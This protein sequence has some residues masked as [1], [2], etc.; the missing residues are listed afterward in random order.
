M[1]LSTHK[2]NDFQ[3]DYSNVREKK[4]TSFQ[5]FKHKDLKAKTQLVV[6]LLN[7]VMQT[8]SSMLADI[9]IPCKERDYSRT[10]CKTLWKVIQENLLY[11]HH[12]IKIY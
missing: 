12:L 5:V 6:S 2:I 9:V 8:C 4:L 1:V 7:T 10:A 3:H 11:C